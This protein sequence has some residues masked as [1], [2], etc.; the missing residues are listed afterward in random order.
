MIRVAL[1]TTWGVQCGVAA[2][3]ENLISH[4][5]DSGIQITPIGAPFNYTALLPRIV[6]QGYD[7]VHFNYDGG[8]LGDISMPGVAR[9]FGKRLVL[10]LNDHWARNNRTGFPWVENFDR[11]VIHQPSEDVYGKFRYVPLAMYD[12]D[13]S[14][15][16]ES[17]TTIGTAG[18]PIGHKRVE[19]VA[20]AAALLVNETERI[21]GCTIIAPASQHADTYAV[22]ARC[23]SAYPATNYLTAW[24][25]QDEVLRILSKNL[26]NIFPMQNSKAGISS[27]ARLG[28]STGS[29]MVLSKCDMYDDILDNPV[30]R[31]EIE[32]VGDNSTENITGRMVADA[33]LRVL[34]NKKR[35]KQLLEDMTWE[36]SSAAYAAIYHELMTEIQ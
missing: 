15:W 3:S 11:V 4:M 33:V 17:N 18:F 16:S 10:T 12:C 7:I 24:L 36:K 30:Y 9:Q 28:I 25:P 1:V 32:W 27:S 34:E 6:N 20:Q 21:K 5:K 31:E 23:L 26:V 13:K 8:F 29:H 14:L 19:L 2:H 35:P 22:R